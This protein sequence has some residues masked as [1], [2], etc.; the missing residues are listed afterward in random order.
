MNQQ[1]ELT[2][3]VAAAHEAVKLNNK[4]TELEIQEVA[5]SGKKHCKYGHLWCVTNTAIYLGRRKC[6]VCAENKLEEL[7]GCANYAYEERALEKLKSGMPQSPF[8]QSCGNLL[9]KAKCAPCYTKLRRERYAEMIKQTYGRDVNVRVR[10]ER[11]V[12][13]LFYYMPKPKERGGTHAEWL[14]N[15]GIKVKTA[16]SER[17]IDFNTPLEDEGDES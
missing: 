1:T 3:D 2:P 14:A 17:R 6:I 7:K 13:D 16:V 15:H 8:C 9:V 4:M 11:E 10:G 12:K 5:K